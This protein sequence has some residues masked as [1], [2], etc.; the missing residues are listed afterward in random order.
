MPRL[1]A[2]ACLCACVV[3]GACGHRDRGPAAAKN[4]V[5][6]ATAKTVI[7][8]SRADVSKLLGVPYYGDDLEWH[9]FSTDPASGKEVTCFIY[10]KA[11]TGIVRDVTC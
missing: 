5:L 4:V 6:A 8:K 2:I 3:V 9:Y 7:G 11:D 10:F 1:F